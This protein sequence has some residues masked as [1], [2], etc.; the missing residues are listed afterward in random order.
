MTNCYDEGHLRA[1]LD[2]ELPAS[3]RAAL[4][5]H[6][7]GCAACQAQLAR[8]R[9]LAA[10]VRSLLPVPQA[11]P[12]ARVALARLRGTTQQTARN[13]P[14]SQGFY[15]QRSKFML[16]NSFRS[17][18]SRSL[19]AAL[20]VIVALVSLL[21]LPP[22]RAAADE[23]LSIFRVQKLVFVPVSRDRLDQLNKLNFDQNTLFVSKPTAGQSAPL[24]TVASAAEAASVVG[25]TVGQPS[26][27][28]SAPLGSEFKVSSPN[29]MQFQVNVA[30]ARQLLALMGVDDVSIPD[31]L[32][33]APIKVDVPAFVL[34]H[35]QGSNYDMTLHQGHSPSVTL[36]DGVDLSQLGKAALRLLGMPAADAEVASRTINWNNT[37]LFP[38][39]ADTADI[40]QVTVG[41]ENALLISGGRRGDQHRQLYWQHGDTFYMLEASG[42]LSEVDMIAGM[43]AAAESIK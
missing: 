30:S 7:A 8:Q 31:A 9:A 24:R 42:S 15:I 29:T 39:P 18:R 41:G 14:A 1:Y 16:S 37:L 19:L 35:Y 33:A 5:A 20:A 26:A 23:L 11:V 21:A 25:G 32:G 40:R 34:A 12:D 10:R 27:F 17:G 13:I 38:F 28:P 6:L 4:A 43:V 36:P 2:G 22:L 3:E